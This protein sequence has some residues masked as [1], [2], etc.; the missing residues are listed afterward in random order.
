MHRVCAASRGSQVTGLRSFRPTE[1]IQPGTLMSDS[2]LVTYWATCFGHIYILLSAGCC[3]AT[4]HRVCAACPHSQVQA[5]SMSDCVNTRE[6]AGIRA[7]P[8]CAKAVQGKLVSCSCLQVNLATGCT[9][10]VQHVNTA[11]CRLH[12]MTEVTH[13]NRHTDILQHV[14]LLDLSAALCRLLCLL[15]CAQGLCNMSLQPAAGC[16]VC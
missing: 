4:V 8:C 5:A 1:H 9:G 13:R 15:L 7:L 3:V 2:I 10:F 12:C 11:S 14:V 16:N 6:Q